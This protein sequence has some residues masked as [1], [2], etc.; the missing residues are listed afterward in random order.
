MDSSRNNPSAVHE[1]LALTK[2]EIIFPVTVEKHLWSLFQSTDPK[3]H[4][5][6]SD[7]V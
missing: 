6:E 7:R 2:L 1:A 5:S 4:C 3:S